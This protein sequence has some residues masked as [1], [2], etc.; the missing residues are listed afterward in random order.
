[1]RLR[2]AGMHK[3]RGAHGC[4]GAAAPGGIACG[5]AGKLLAAS[6]PRAGYLSLLVQ[7]KVTKRKHTR[8]RR[9]P[10]RFSPRPGAS[11]TRRALNNALRARTPARDDSRPGLRCSA[12][13]TGAEV[14]TAEEIRKFLPKARVKRC[15]FT[16][17]GKPV[18][19]PRKRRARR[20]LRRSE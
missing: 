7:R 19:S 16:N 9:R 6:A 20:L 14:K 15:N 5:D 3:C 18:L 10:L 13:A 4:A 2:R 8:S 17:T 1:M 12:A 11:R